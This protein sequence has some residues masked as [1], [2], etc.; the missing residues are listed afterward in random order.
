[1]NTSR[2]I[3]V[4]VVLAAALASGCSSG[5]ASGHFGDGVVVSKPE[6]GWPWGV[7]FREL[8]PDATGTA[9]VNLRLTEVDYRLLSS[10]EMQVE[11]EVV[12]EEGEIKA[13]RVV[14]SGIEYEGLHQFADDEGEVARTGRRLSFIMNGDP[15]RASE[16]LELKVRKVKGPAGA[17]EVFDAAVYGQNW[18]EMA[19]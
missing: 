16:R 8:R 4:V 10:G 7:E 2:L 17:L 11:I 18:I 14:K 13:S 15:L 12:S 5:S 1:M 6:R 9:R 3:A 19:M